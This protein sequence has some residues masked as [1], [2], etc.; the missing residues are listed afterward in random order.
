MGA[1]IMDNDDFFQKMISEFN[2]IENLY[3]SI[4]IVDPIKKEV[5]KIIKGSTEL[6]NENNT[7]Y[8]FWQSP[9]W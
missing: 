8:G 2:F 4:R 6:I 1:L 5:S 7:C 9:V 3:E